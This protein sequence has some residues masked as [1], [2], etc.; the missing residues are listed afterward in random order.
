[1]SVLHVRS[2]VRN[3]LSSWTFCPII[4]DNDLGS[5]PINNAFCK[6]SILESQADIVS[7]GLTS[8]DRHIGQVYVQVFA[9]IGEGDQ[10]ISLLADKLIPLFRK[11]SM[12]GITFLLPRIDIVGNTGEG[13]WL[14]NVV[15]PYVYDEETAAVV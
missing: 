8:L 5:T 15:S 1:M 14:I 4:Y 12:E 3:I 9:P 2:I 11:I 7:F 10:R 6:V 13:F